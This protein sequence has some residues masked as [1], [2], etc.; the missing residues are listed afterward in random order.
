MGIVTGP[1]RVEVNGVE[2]SI[3]IRGDGPPLYF[4]T[5]GWG[6]SIHGYRHL[7]PLEERFTVVW[8]ETRGTGESSAPADDDYRLS[9]FTSDA[10]ALREALEI[11][12]WWVAGHSWGAACAQDYVAHLPERCLGAI[13]L[14]T[15]VPT[16]PSNFEDLLERSLARA[17]DP[18]CDDALAAFSREPTTDEE[19]T[20]MLGDILP[21]YFVTLEAAARFHAELEGMSCRVAAMVAEE[22]HN[23]DRSSIDLLPS[24]DVPTV[25]V[26]GSG[27]VICSPPKNLRVH[28]AIPGS[29]FV[30]VENAG[31]FPWYENPDQFWPGLHSALDALDA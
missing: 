11:D 27:D 17:G 1:Q 23:V 12:Q 26:A 2:L 28:H 18:G 30:L 24:I 16:D 3:E 6:A 14:C 20:Q 13:L 8:T 21:L 10:D 7:Q 9:T 5:P 25:V 31:H 19:A 22:P 15:L 29:K 4:P